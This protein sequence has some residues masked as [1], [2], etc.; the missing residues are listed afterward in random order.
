VLPRAHGRALAGTRGHG[1]SWAA[2]KRALALKISLNFK[3]ST[4]FIIQIG[5]LS[6]SKIHQSLQVYSLKYK[7]KL[8][9]L[10]QHQNP[11]GLQVTNSGTNS[12]LN[13][14]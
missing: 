14:P 1:L 8:Y 3:I 10:D 13:L 6:M 11:R 4:N 5:D 9:F 12:N 7:E 2:G